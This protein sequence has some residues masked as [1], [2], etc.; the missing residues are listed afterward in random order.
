MFGSQHQLQTS[1]DSG[2][3]VTRNPG[4]LIIL[5]SQ[6]ASTYTETDSDTHDCYSITITPVTRTKALQKREPMIK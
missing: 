5:S 1:G 2:L 3:S 6:Q 4:M